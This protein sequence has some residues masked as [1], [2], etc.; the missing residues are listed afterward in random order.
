MSGTVLDTGLGG[1]TSDTPGQSDVIAA[2]LV[3]ETVQGIV[4]HEGTVQVAF[5]FAYSGATLS[6]QA[7][8]Q[9]IADAALYAALNASS[10]AAAS[11]VWNN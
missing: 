2:Q 5:L 8:Q 4:T 9:V 10:L 1:V 3:D 11:I 6:F 7:F